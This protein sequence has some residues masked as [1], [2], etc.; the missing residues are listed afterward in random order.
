VT[1]DAEIS[2]PPT[3]TSRGERRRALQAERQRQVESPARTDGPPV[4]P[5]LVR[6]YARIAA[7]IPSVPSPI[8]PGRGSPSDPGSTP[9]RSVP[10]R[11]AVERL[12]PADPEAD[13]PV[14][15]A[16]ETA[17]G[18]PPR[19]QTGIEGDA[20]PA[21]ADAMA[22]GQANPGTPM[23]GAAAPSDPPQA[24][25]P[26]GPESTEQRPEPTEPRPEPTEP[27]PE[28]T[29][30]R[31]NPP[32]PLQAWPDPAPKPPPAPPET[33]PP[34][35][36]AFTPVI[37]PDPLPFD[38]DP[39]S[40]GG[41]EHVSV[42]QG[43]DDDWLRTLRQPADEEPWTGPHDPST[44][45]PPAIGVKGPAEPPERADDRTDESDD[46]QDVGLDVGDDQHAYRQRD[47]DD[48]HD[49]RDEDLN[50]GPNDGSIDRPS[51]DLSEERNDAQDTEP[52]TDHGAGLDPDGDAAEDD[53]LRVEA[54][55]VHGESLIA[56]S[57]APPEREPADAL[58]LAGEP[59]RPQPSR[60]AGRPLGEGSPAATSEHRRSFGRAPAER[61]SQALS[62]GDDGTAD[63]PGD[64]PRAERWADLVD[65]GGGGAE[66]EDR[67][68][69]A[70][71]TPGEDD[72]ELIRG[73]LAPVLRRSTQRATHPT[74]STPV[75]RPPAAVSGPADGP[76]A[77]AP[78]RD[79]PVSWEEALAVD[80]VP[81]KGGRRRGRRVAKAR[82]VSG[83]P[84]EY[85]PRTSRDRSL[86]LL[87]VG[88]LLVLVVLLGVVVWAFWPQVLGARSLPAP[89]VPGSSAAVDG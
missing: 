18:D 87:V 69:A 9:V 56:G 80:V 73:T 40:N 48:A 14:L 59:D 27:R 38:L 17:A 53:D 39:R 26:P 21:D 41:W 63:E 33:A 81:G 65:G 78:P 36:S 49:A 29:E 72:E 89:V 57:T 74:G 11:D 35:W 52:D 10:V 22:Q 43:D 1:D 45:E 70:D 51:K 15:A 58:E 55:P 4:P 42:R 6:P 20:Q 5:A 30:P 75:I 60:G 67:D 16:P 13:E 84:G 3:P 62:R 8:E 7:P 64:V 24:P 76:G 83:G 19:A 46:Q 44:S 71:T 25:P 85:R 50:D 86:T 28:P 66:T 77:A 31:P 23:A 47:Q 32:D 79:P 37:P 82:H 54:D 68:E 2:G 61:L 34:G 12:T 88:M